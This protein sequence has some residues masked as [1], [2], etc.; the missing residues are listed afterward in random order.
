[1]SIEIVS[2]VA[3]QVPLPSLQVVAQWQWQEWGRREGKNVEQIASFLKAQ[4]TVH[5]IPQA[6]VLL[7][8]GAPAGTAT[9]DHADLGAR[10]DLTP[11][12]ANVF[13]SPNFRGRGHARRLVRHIEAAAHACGIAILYLHTENA[14]A[15]YA[16]LG[17]AKIDTADYHGHAVTVM[18]KVLPDGA[19]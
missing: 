2:L 1:M 15:L 16:G 8:D 4:C 13:V 3:M 5:S 17:W 6:V 7:E 11:W 14:T 9:L 12:L 18:R 19:V 10:P